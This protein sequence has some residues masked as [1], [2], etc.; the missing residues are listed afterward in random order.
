MKK[1]FKAISLFSGAGGL[2]L[3]FHSTGMVTSLACY[4]VDPIFSETLRV[5][6]HRLGAG[7][8]DLQPTIYQE[9]LSDE[10][11]LE[12]ITARSNGVDIIFGGPPC[13]SFSIMGKKDGIND[14]RGALIFSFAKVVASLKPRCFLFENVPNFASIDS[15]RTARNFIQAFEERGYSTWSGILCAADFGAYTFRRRFFVFGSLERTKLS[16]PVPTHSELTQDG[17]PGIGLAPWRKC[18]EIFEGI[19]AWLA[20][21]LPLLNHEAVK[22]KPE[23]IDRFRALHYGETDPVRKRNRLDPRKPAH[24]V[25]VGGVP[26]K[27]QARPHIHPYLPRELTPRECAA[28]QGFPLDWQFC[29]KSDAV[30]L[31][32]ANAVP[33][34]LAQGVANHLVGMLSGDE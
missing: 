6:A 3:G 17:L 13:Q 29:G 20:R 19:E 4:E 14:S 18:G 12:Q 27:S 21:G 7:S 25:Y 1:T 28:I 31:Q 26:G 34:Q 32:A 5:N 10:A 2:D 9:D 11:V 33:V 8:S 23:V 22:H 15:G 24:S 16:S 30:M